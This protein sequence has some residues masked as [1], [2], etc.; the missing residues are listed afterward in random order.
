MSIL[1]QLELLPLSAREAKF[2]QRHF[3]EPI[4]IPHN[5]HKEMNIEGGAKFLDW[6]QNTVHGNNILHSEFEEVCRRIS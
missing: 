1:E 6:W 4:R 2:V 5:P 3:K